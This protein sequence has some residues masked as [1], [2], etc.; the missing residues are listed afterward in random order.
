MSAASGGSEPAI[1]LDRVRGALVGGAGPGIGGGAPGIWAP[2]HLAAA[3]RRAAGLAS[4]GEVLRVLRTFD[5]ETTGLGVL[6]PLVNLPGVTDVLVNAADEV[7]I[8]RDGVLSRVPVELGGAEGVRRLAVRLAAA[9]GRRLDDAAPIVDVPLP[10]GHRLSAVLGCLTGA[11]PLICVRTAAPRARPLVDVVGSSADAGLLTALLR[12]LVAARLT[13]V[14]SGVTGSGKTTLL[15]ALLGE[16]G[17]EQRVVILEDTPELRPRC[18][19]VV[20]LRTRSAN[21]EGAGEVTL[22]DLVRASLRLRPDRLVLG[23]VRGEEVVD[24]LAALTAGHSGSWTTVHAERAA[25][26]PG[27]LV[28]LGSLV[29]LPPRAV[30]ELVAA[31]VQVVVSVAR[32]PAGTTGPTEGDRAPAPAVTGRAAPSPRHVAEIAVLRRR[33]HAVPKV[34]PAVVMGAGPPPAG[35]ALAGP[36]AVYLAHLLAAHGQ[37]E[38]AGQLRDLAAAGVPAIVARPG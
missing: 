4:D 12:A 3:V 9:A 21:V 10:G 8:E 15:G 20:R 27:R 18:R 38:A 7:W 26:V 25:A 13:G 29:G 23:E 19:Q 2:E 14:V 30:A 17:P 5:A 33:A 35:R 22:R 11:D 36:G 32:A 6:E 24:L 28:A 1:V 31:S 37:A 16:V 34:V